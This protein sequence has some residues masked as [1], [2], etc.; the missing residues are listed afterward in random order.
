MAAGDL[1]AR[2]PHLCS[3]DIA[4]SGPGHAAARSKRTRRN[5]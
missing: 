5:V 2:R 4:A 1:T 3:L